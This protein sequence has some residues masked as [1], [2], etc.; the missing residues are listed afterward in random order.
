MIAPQYCKF[1]TDRKIEGLGVALVTPFTKDLSI[2]FAALGNIIEHTLKGEADYLVA[3]GTTAETP[4]LSNEEKQ[5]V[6][7][8]ISEKVDGKVP[9]VIGIGGNNT[10]KVVEKLQ[11]F[12]LEGYDAVLSVTPYYNKPTQEGLF[13][14]FKEICDNSPL[15]LIL[16]NVPGRT[17]VNLT[18]HTTLRLAE[19]SPRIIAI[20]EA[21]GN[22]SQCEEIINNSPETFNLISG[23]D[24]LIAPLMQRGASGIISVM[25]NALPVEVKNIVNLCKT[26]QFEE[27]LKIQDSFNPLIGT[28]FE[29]GNPGGVK[30][31]L[32]QMELCQNI[33]RLPLVKVSDNLENKIKKFLL[34]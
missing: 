3:L 32:H 2:D 14:H 10:R 19:Y 25:A 5:S 7:T 17:G 6:A 15:P 22:I 28:L 21:S 31:M 29:E 18:S 24:A 1:M 20:K 33:L 23:D 8:F 9:L 11:T 4:T 34:S 12:N 16:Y 30:A 27:A 26:K 13:C